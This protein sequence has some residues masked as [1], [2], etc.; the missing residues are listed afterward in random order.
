MIVLLLL[1]TGCFSF[2]ED[3]GTVGNPRTVVSRAISVPRTMDGVVNI[4]SL[5]ADIETEVQE[6]LPGAYLRGFVF[7]GQGKDL[8]TLDGRIIFA[9]VQVCSGILGERIVVA[10]GT[11]DT[12]Q[13]TLTISTVDLTNYYPSTSPLVLRKGLSLTEIAAI[14]YTQ[15]EDMGFGHHEITLTR[16]PDNEWVVVCG[17]FGTLEQE[18]RF[19]I[20]SVT[21]EVT[22]VT[23]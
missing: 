2:Q 23:Q 1:T 19:K 6:V 11:V 16:L 3:Y 13:R 21:G 10:D 18:C 15:L 17:E 22:N 12:E 8:A 5:L 9:F 20:D 7:A 4:D 14:A